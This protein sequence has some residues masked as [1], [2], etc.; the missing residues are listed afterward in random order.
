MAKKR[1]MNLG[2]STD[3]DAISLS[4]LPP[5]SQGQLGGIYE[6]NEK[7]WQMFKLVDAGPSVAGD[8]G[9]IKSYDGKYE[10]T[11]TIGNSS[12]NEVAGVFPTAVALNN[13]T[14]LR[15]GGLIDV[16]AGAGTFARGTHAVSDTS[17]N[18]VIPQP[19]DTS[20]T[21]TK[22][23]VVGVAQGASAS[24]LVSVALTLDY[25]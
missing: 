2:F 17:G 9:Y 7:R 6:Q 12:R 16:K 23:Q 22:H 18:Q 3:P 21:Q 25:L 10:A 19:V 20:T 8:L 15:V 1:Y 13:F 4:A 5:Q 14:L 24:S 11:R